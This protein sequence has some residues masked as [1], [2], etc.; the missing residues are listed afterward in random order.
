MQTQD[1]AP[2][3]NQMSKALG[4]KIGTQVT[5]EEL[6][7][8]FENYLRYGVPP[9][10]AVKT[11]LR[12]HGV[13]VAPTT[14][15]AA[16]TPAAPPTLGRI[17]L[18]QLPPTASS[19]HVKARVL[20]ITTKQ[21]TARGETRDIVTGLL[22]DESGTAPFT[23][24]RPLEGLEKG[25]VVEITGAY[26]KEF[27]GQG[28]VNLGDRTRIQRVE[29]D[30]MPRPPTPTNEVT[31]AALKEGLRGVKVT[32]RVLDVATRTV[33]VAGTPKT[34]WGGNFADATGHVEFTSWA[35]HGLVAGAAVTIE[36][37]YVRAFRNVPQLTFDAEAK[38]TPAEG[39][40]EAAS[41]RTAP[42]T[43]LWVL[44]ERGSANDI[45]VTGTLLEV[46]PGSGLIFRCPA[47]HEGKVCGRVVAAGACRLHGKQEG[48][49][50]LRVKAILDDG[51]GAVALT[52][53]RELTEQ[54]LGKTLD[55]AKAEAQA[56]F[57]PDLVV[58][59]LKE[60]VTGRIYTVNGFARSDDYGLALIARTLAPATEDVPAAA[61]AL[62]E[63]GAF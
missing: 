38:V 24:W 42:A 6:Q 23:S 62:L 43:A 19:V 45:T 50:D 48:Q 55:Q 9:E 47:P 11:I 46:R 32:G 30:D 22:G 37:A 59:Q 7:A 28:Q 21:V 14:P 2:Y 12:H 1:L 31:V 34:L 60:R 61:K 20:S 40:P 15:T 26:T 33:T 25:D 13:G 63:G 18:A 44:Q 39:V 5:Q 16:G 3:Y 36:G 57:R 58:E 53:G 17:P 27:R 35:D 8:E 10:Q 41:L 4:S 49:P 29:G 56:A 51:T 54:L 52:V